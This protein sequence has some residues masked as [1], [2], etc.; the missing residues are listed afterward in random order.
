MQAV[1]LKII[2]S[3]F[4]YCYQTVQVR[5]LPVISQLCPIWSLMASIWRVKTFWQASVRIIINLCSCVNWWARNVL[6]LTL[7]VPSSSNSI[8]WINNFRR[9]ISFTRSWNLYRLFQDSNKWSTR[10]IFPLSGMICDKHFKT[11]DECLTAL[12]P[13]NCTTGVLLFS[14]RHPYH[15]HKH[16]SI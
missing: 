11:H 9:S 13:T 1:E 8:W 5:V 7:P 6:T 3:Y 2:H 14:L 12:S 16:I 4:I 15:K 10:A